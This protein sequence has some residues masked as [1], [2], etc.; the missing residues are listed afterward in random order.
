[1]FSRR[2]PGKQREEVA[3]V[4]TI[5][6]EAAAVLVLSEFAQAQAAQPVSIYVNAVQGDKLI[7][8]LRQGNFRLFE[9]GQ[10]R[11]FRLTEPEQPISVA[12]LVEYSQSS[13]VYFEDIQTATLSFMKEA[14]EG[15]WY[16]L[17]TFSKDI[18]IHVDFTKLGGRI[19]EAFSD[20]GTPIWSEINTHDAVY[21][22][23]DVLGRLPGR[24]LLIV[25]GSGVDTF[26][27]RNLDQSRKKIQSTNVTVYGVA[28]GS[29]FRGMYQAYLRGSTQ[30]SL[31]QAE[32]YMPMLA[33]E[34]GGEAWF[35]RLSAY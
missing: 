6:L 17:A 30:L 19:T 5:C 25:I 23:L 16:A 33:N 3:A 35:R 27:E 22:L 18:E 34:S 4:V 2:A 9:D 1:M 29:Q 7:G 32:S 31:L 10:S 28:A 12:L 24:R 20:L 14:P 26:S 8:G 13:Y 11:E 21:E 15:N